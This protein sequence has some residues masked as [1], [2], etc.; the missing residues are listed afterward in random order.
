MPIA[1]SINP[2]KKEI[3]VLTRVNIQNSSRL[4]RPLKLA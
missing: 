2:V 1:P 3:I 4:A